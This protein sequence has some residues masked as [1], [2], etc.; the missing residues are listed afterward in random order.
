MVLDRS[1]IYT[2]D[3]FRPGIRTYAA[4]P[5]DIIVSVFGAPYAA[6]KQSVNDVQE[7]LKIRDQGRY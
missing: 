5:S 2:S 6:G 3:T 1:G 7:V 4:D